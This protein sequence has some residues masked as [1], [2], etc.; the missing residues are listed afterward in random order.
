MGCR[1]RARP[2][3]RRSGMC[4]G[5]ASIPSRSATVW[6][7]CALGDGEPCRDRADAVIAIPPGSG[8]AAA[9]TLVDLRD[10]ELFVGTPVGLMPGRALLNPCASGGVGLAAIQIA[11]ARGRGGHRTA[12]SAAKRA[13]LRLVGADHVCD[14]RELAC[15][16]GARRRPGGAGRYRAQLALRRGGW[17]RARTAEAVRP[18]CR[19]GKRISTRTG[20]PPRPLRRKRVV[21]SGRYQTVAGAPPGTP[22]RRCWTKWK[23]RRAGDIRP[24]AYRS[25]AFAEIPTPSA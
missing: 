8:F 1:R 16:G 24:L 22:P 4:A 2:R 21:F 10:R 15:R 17:R 5:D 20:V 7:V 19:A 25:F 9:A 18:L 23:P 6:R 14:S 12:G 3:M 11:K 13:F